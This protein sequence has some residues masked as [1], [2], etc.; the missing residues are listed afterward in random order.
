MKKKHILIAAI[1]IS[2]LAFYSCKKQLNVTKD[3]V[4]REAGGAQA[5]Y[6]NSIVLGAYTQLQSLTANNSML[7]TS[8]ETTDALIVPARIGGDWLDAGLWQPLWLHTYAPGNSNFG[9]SWDN[10]YNAIGQIN[11][12]IDLLKGLPQTNSTSYSIAELQTLRDYY[13]FLLLVNFGRIPYITSSST[14]A[15]TVANQDASKTFQALVDELTAN[16]PKLSSKTPAQDPSQYGRLNKW[17]AYFLLAKL[18][19]NQNVI[20]G[21]TDNTG[22]TKCS[23]YCDSLMTSG[24]SLMP[25][26]LDNFSSTNTN[27]T[28]NIFVIPYDHINAQGLQIQMMTFHYNQA[29][30]YNWGSTGGPWN[31]F[32]A[33]ADYYGLF[34][35][36]DS[37]K[38]G[39][40]H[41]IQYAADGVTPLTTRASDSSLVLNFRPQVS[42]LYN[43]TEY[44]GVRQQ[45]WALTPGYANQDADFALF[46]YSDV[47]LMKA[48]C[49]L[50]LGNATAALTYTAPVRQR[51][52]LANFNAGAFNADSLLAERG[53]EFVWEGWRRQDL[54]RFGHFGDKRQFKNYTDPSDKHYE[55]LPIPTREILKN[56]HLTQNPNY[57]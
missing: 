36:A 20:T 30:K 39:W 37:R 18:Y 50:R 21:S 25:N 11:I 41:G 31:G 16:G 10:A 53:R 2:G 40:Q 6:L 54:I 35:N 51:A 47:L 57:Q 7:L 14:D 44:D 43:A 15:S 46:R 24:Y 49:E 9:D 3:S 45:K 29:A 42:S 55:L 52:G 28:E 34:N 17:G 48:E 56:S 12:T 32:C 33:N 8:E 1:L 26:F 5:A 23:Q 13:Y 22:Y 19:L 38:A 4:T 27:S